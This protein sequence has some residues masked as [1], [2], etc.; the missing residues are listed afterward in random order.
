MAGLRRVLNI[1]GMPVVWVATSKTRAK[2]D[3]GDG[4]RCTIPFR[5]NMVLLAI[6]NTVLRYSFT[7]YNAS[8]QISGPVLIRFPM[9]SQ[10]HRDLN[11]IPDELTPHELNS[12]SG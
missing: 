2:V 9:C 3:C 12:G 6:L 10:M 7:Y 8:L 5:L 1:L 4:C 11:A